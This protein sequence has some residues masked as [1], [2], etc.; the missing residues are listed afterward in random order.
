VF[1][2]YLKEKLKAKKEKRQDA[3]KEAV[4]KN[5]TLPYPTNDVLRAEAEEAKPEVYFLV[6]DESGAPIRRVE[7]SIEAG[8]QRAAWDL[9]Y[10]AASLREHKEDGE[11][12][13]P[14]GAQGPLVMSGSYTV[15]LFQKLDGTVTELAGAQSFKVLADGT[16]SLS[17]ADRAAQEEFQR[18]VARLYRAVSGAVHTADD[19]ETRLK[20]IREALRETPA[21]EKLL[22]GAGDSFAG[23]TRG[24]LRALR[25][26]TEMHKLNEPIPS[27]INDR[28]NAIMEGERFALVKPTQTHIDDYNIAAGEFTE[29]LGKLRAL[30]EVDLAKLEKDM[31]GAGA[32]W[33]PG[34]VP[35]WSEK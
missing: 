33:T 3:E 32:P 15:R 25:G 31:E 29:Q 16:S 4:K 28:V 2:A 9:R 11:D 14:A 8:F 7:G 35:E 20:S 17:A 6:Y 27:S 21:A 30:V 24:I 13:A 26:D 12:F 23:A 10:P 22:G 19:V 34:R 1:T 5:Q 18:K